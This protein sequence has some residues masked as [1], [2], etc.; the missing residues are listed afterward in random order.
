MIWKF[1]LSIVAVLAVYIVQLDTIGGERKTAALLL[2]LT[3]CV[4]VIRAWRKQKRTIPI[5]AGV[6]YLIAYATE[7]GTARKLARQTLKQLKHNKVTGQ[8]IELNELL[9]APAPSKG[10]FVV[11]STSGQGDAPRTGRNWLDHRDKG[12]DQFSQLP[13][14][15]L[16]LGDRHYRQFCGFG[17]K[18]DSVLRAAG[19]KPMFE[20][21]M[22]SQANEEHLKAWLN[23]VA[24]H[25]QLT[26][27]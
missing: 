11:A 22:V 2:L 19:A 25:T 13:Y 20:M 23:Q 6:D 18:V 27:H 15:I 17:V 7:T 10:L 14:A 26:Q 16:G 8:V 9:S 4:V 1:T 21:F 12:M 3:Y 24:I 5:Q